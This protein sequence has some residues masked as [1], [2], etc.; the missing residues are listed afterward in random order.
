MARTGVPSR[1][2]VTD[3]SVGVQ[4]ECVMLDKGPHIAATTRFLGN[5]LERMQEHRVKKRAM[6]RRL[7]VADDLGNSG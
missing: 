2:E 4:A 7:H 6:L 3:A 5:V 1:A